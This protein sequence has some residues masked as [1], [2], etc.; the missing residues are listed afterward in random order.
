MTWILDGNNILGHLADRE[1][2]DPGRE[3]LLERLLSGGAPTP[4]TVVFDG[5]PPEGRRGGERRGKIAVAYGGKCS[6]DDVIAGLARPGDTVVTADRELLARCREK[7]TRG[8]APGDFL[9]SLRKPRRPKE[10][11]KPAPGEVDVE[12][13]MAYFRRKPGK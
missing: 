2:R 13:W 11:E 4:L 8:M 10:S 7:G 3:G 1:G 6:A 9:D 5:P 12:F